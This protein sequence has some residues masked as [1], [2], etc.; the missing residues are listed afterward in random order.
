MNTSRAETKIK[1][2]KIKAS[3]TV[4]FNLISVMCYVVFLSLLF[5]IFINDLQSVYLF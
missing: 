1:P 5:T 3:T 4:G 2:K